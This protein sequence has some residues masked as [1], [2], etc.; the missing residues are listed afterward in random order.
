M[1]RAETGKIIVILGGLWLVLWRTG[2]RSGR[3][4]REFASP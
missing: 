3:V 4:F 2:R 1:F